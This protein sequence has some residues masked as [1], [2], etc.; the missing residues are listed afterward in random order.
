MAAPWNIRV[1]P[2]STDGRILAA[3]YHWVEVRKKGKWQDAGTSKTW[4][5]AFLMGLIA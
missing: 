5:E 2:V 4:F 3:D 1:T